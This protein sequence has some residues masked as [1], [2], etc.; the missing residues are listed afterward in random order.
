ML[1][2][3]VFKPATTKPSKALGV[4]SMLD[5]AVTRARL[6]LSQKFQILGEPVHSTGGIVA[7]GKRQQ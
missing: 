6:P 3:R 1:A 4:Q 7:K 2:L 5:P